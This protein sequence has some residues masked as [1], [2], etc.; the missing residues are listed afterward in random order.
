MK[1]LIKKF[2]KTAKNVGK[3]M[4]MR[5]VLIW[6]NMLKNVNNENKLWNLR[7]L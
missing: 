7:D 4:N 2:G 1:I 3:L 5:E 6:I